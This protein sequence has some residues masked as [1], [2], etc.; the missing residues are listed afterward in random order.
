[1]KIRLVSLIATSVLSL[2]LLTTAQ[3][4]QA[5]S[6]VTRAIPIGTPSKIPGV[7]VINAPEVIK[8]ADSDEEIVIFDSRSAVERKQGKIAW[9]ESFNP[10]QLSAKRLA[11]SIA[12]T[13]TVVVFYGDKNCPDAAKGAGLAVS[14][15]YK[16]VYWFRGG[17]A[18]WTKSGLRMD[19]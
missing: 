10:K 11:D 18:E 4:E 2:A 14:K 9:S 13:D 1:M 6:K 15:G 5:D 3:A 8:L 12:S 7:L 19:M 16:S 17:Y